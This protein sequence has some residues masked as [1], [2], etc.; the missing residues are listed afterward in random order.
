MAFVRT[1]EMEGTWVLTLISFR[2]YSKI[3][4]KTRNF[5]L[6]TQAYFCVVVGNFVG[7]LPKS[8]VWG[9][10][11]LGS[12]YSFSMQTRETLALARI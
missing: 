3:L 1:Q 8:L 10:E 11:S 4:V 2:E 9:N 12:T 7:I 6:P 5:F